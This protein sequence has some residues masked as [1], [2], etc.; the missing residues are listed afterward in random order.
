M[1]KGLLDP[2][3]CDCIARW[4]SVPPVLETSSKRALLGSVRARDHTMREVG[5]TGICAM[6]V[7]TIQNAALTIFM[8]LSYRNGAQTYSGPVVVLCVECL[9]LLSCFVISSM[10]VRVKD[11]KSIVTGVCHNLG[12]SVPS[13]MYVAQNN[14]LIVAVNHLSQTSFIV[15]S[16]GKIITSALFSYILLRK[17]FARRQIYAL[18]MLACGIALVQLQNSNTGLIASHSTNY[19]GLC[20]MLVANIMSGYA[21]VFLERLFKANKESIWVRNIHLCLFSIPISILSIVVDRRGGHI[22]IKPLPL[23]SGFDSVVICVVLL[24]AVGGLITAFVMRF[25]SAVL[26]C[27]A[28]SLS[29]CLCTIVASFQG[30]VPSSWVLFGILLVSTSIFVYIVDPRASQ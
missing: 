23:F 21:G 6:C 14:L 9:K 20:A 29:I 18:C 25:A 16:Q 26:K 19:V 30:D 7:L 3:R 17:R 13:L 15:A 22:G 12:L 1:E 2:S 27:F 5:V 28:V 11:M 4:R 8:K 24:N 10:R